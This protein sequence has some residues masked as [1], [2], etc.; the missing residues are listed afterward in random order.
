MQQC[1]ISPGVGRFSHINTQEEYA[2]DRPVKV[3]HRIVRK[4]DIH[5]LT[6]ACTSQPCLTGL[7]EKGF[8]GLEYLIQE[9]KKTLIDQFRKSLLYSPP[10]SI[11][12]RRLMGESRLSADVLALLASTTSL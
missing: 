2:F 3:A 10:V 5:L 12:V 8:A 7:G 6:F 1:S 11:S 4:V 9:V